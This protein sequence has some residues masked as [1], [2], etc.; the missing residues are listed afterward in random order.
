A[1]T[2]FGPYAGARYLVIEVEGLA[3][4]GIEKHQLV[5]WGR[6]YEHVVQNLS[7]KQKDA[8]VDFL[9]RKRQGAI[10]GV[11]RSQKQIVRLG[12]TSKALATVFTTLV[13]YCLLVR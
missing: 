12:S 9:D 8:L 2:G 10:Y 7:Q 13:S 3:L 1:A 4:L 6:D 11:H 5:L